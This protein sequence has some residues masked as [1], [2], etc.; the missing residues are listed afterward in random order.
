MQSEEPICRF[1]DALPRF[2]NLVVQSLGETALDQHAFLR[3]TDGVLS[4]ILRGNIDEG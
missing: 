3:D 2:V 1:D 4:L